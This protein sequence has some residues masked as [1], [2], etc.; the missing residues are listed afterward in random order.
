MDA[1][2]CLQP[3]INALVEVA[4]WLYV[5]FCMLLISRWYSYGNMDGIHTTTQPLKN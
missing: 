4:F 2:K 1:V 5:Y 3:L